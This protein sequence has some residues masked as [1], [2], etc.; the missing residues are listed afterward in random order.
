M[1]PP[2]PGSAPNTGPAL[3]TLMGAR[4]TATLGSD[5]GILMSL[6]DKVRDG[7]WEVLQSCLGPQ[8]D[9]RT[10]SRLRRFAGDHEIDA[11]RILPPIKSV[12]FLLRTAASN[13]TPREAFLSDVRALTPPA[14]Q[15]ALCE[16]LGGVFDQAFPTLRR[17]VV[18]RS[19]AEHGTLAHDVHWRLAT[20]QASDHGVALDVP[21]T[22]LTFVCQ[23]GQ[24]Q[25]NV[26]I[27]LLPDTLAK[28]RDVCDKILKG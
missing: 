21:L 16:L 13:N 6:P 23:E 7:F 19:V 14:D 22:A 5:L 27:Q 10:V 20:L 11:E 28:L 3:Q 17:E 2:H 8:L 26:S 18:M 15:D 1:T 24:T 4:A 12:R 25:R 9:E